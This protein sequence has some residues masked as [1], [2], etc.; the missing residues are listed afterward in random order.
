MRTPWLVVI[1]PPPVFTVAFY[2]SRDTSKP[3][4]IKR[5]LQ[6]RPKNAKNVVLLPGRACTGLPTDLLPVP[7]G[8]ITAGC[9]AGL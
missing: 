4:T 6:E 1:V 2:V 5:N 8:G 3:E 9:D 7:S